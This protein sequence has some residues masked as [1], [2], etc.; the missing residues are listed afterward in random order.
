MDESMSLME[1]LDVR[2]D[3]FSKGQKRIADF[4][5]NHYDKAAMYT[6]AKL[7]KEVGVS[8]STV[9]R[10]AYELEYDG[11]PELLKAIAATVRTH[12]NSIQRLENAAL[13]MEEGDNLLTSILKDDRMRIKE[14]AQSVDVEMFD[15]VVDAIVNADNIY[16][17]G[18]RSTWYLAGM[19]GYYFHMIFDQVHVL[20]GS[21]N[22]DTL[23][24][25][26]RIKKNDIF[27]GISFPRYS[28]RT[29][30]AMQLAKK[31]GA[32]TITITDSMQSPLI[33]YADYPLIAKSDVMA[34]VDS[35]TAPISLI[36][37]LVVAVCM[38]KKD[39]LE[40]RLHVLE[41]LWNEYKVYDDH[42]ID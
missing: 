35:L 33:E 10:F 23:E 39:D 36:N 26:C 41:E 32:K 14:T 13:R 3:N 29:A 7:G 28:L 30:S 4:L 2:Y 27:I 18:V 6:A 17:L 15:K 42:V 12:S 19:M 31:N 37:A 22:V 5:R 16:I 24:E 1:R 38:K 11:Y 9:V 20:E 8:E 21:G 34:I 40:A 25:I